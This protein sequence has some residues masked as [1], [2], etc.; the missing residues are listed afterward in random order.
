MASQKW[1]AR[2]RDL[3]ADLKEKG[4]AVPRPYAGSDDDGENAERWAEAMEKALDV[5]AAQAARNDDDYLEKRHQYTQ[6]LCKDFERMFGHVEAGLG[7]DDADQV[8]LDAEHN[9]HADAGKVV[10][11]PQQLHSE[12]ETVLGGADGEAARARI[13]EVAH[14]GEQ[15]EIALHDETPAQMAAL[16]NSG[17][18]VAYNHVCKTMM[19]DKKQVLLLMCGGPGTGKTYTC[20]AIESLGKYKGTLLFCCVVFVFKYGTDRPSIN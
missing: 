17:Q 7:I 19:E 4:A 8:G 6:Q 10:L 15:K 9:P 18:R 1:R 13:D 12:R 3:W 14:G 11:E 16:L 5:L 20:Q 2:A